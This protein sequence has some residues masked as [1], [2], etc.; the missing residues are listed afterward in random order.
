[1]I[2]SLVTCPNCNSDET[3]EVYMDDGKGREGFA[4]VCENCGC[5]WDEMEREYES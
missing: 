4:R 2:P 1:M 3:K 5:I